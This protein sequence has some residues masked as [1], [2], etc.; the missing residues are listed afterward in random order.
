MK[1]KMTIIL[2]AAPIL[3]I[4]FPFVYSL[5]GAVFGGDPHADFPLLEYPDPAQ[6]KECVRETE[7]MRFHHMDLL[8]ELRIKVVRD[9]QPQELGIK[10][11]R[12]CHPNKDQFC[13]RC[14]DTVSLYPDC[15][16]CHYYPDNPEEEPEDTHL[17][18]TKARLGKML[19][20]PDDL[21]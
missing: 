17:K 20:G 3:I 14:H 1:N 8:K 7:Y 4:V 16:G 15:W 11:C 6:Y 13:N 9:G 5:A 21:L 18:E 12:G 19:S 10:S 2:V